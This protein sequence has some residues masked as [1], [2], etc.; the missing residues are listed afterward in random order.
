VATAVV[1]SII[2]VSVAVVSVGVIG[3]VGVVGV[4]LEILAA[5]SE[6]FDWLLWL[7][8]SAQ[9]D[10]NRRKKILILIRINSFDSIKKC[11]YDTVDN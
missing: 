10:R 8:E 3:V 5:L 6:V 4:V 2:A 9:L 11:L 1:V 7:C